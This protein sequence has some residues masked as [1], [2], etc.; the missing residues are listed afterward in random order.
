M[1]VPAFGFWCYRIAIDYCRRHTTRVHA[2]E[3]LEMWRAEA[4]A[5]WAA[6]LVC[7]DGLPHPVCKAEQRPLD[8]LPTS[9]R[10]SVE[11]D[12]KVVEGGDE[13]HG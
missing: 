4:L 10:R 5:T 12:A 1:R 7:M 13:P 6:S 11:A 8:V 2:I 9:E 3:M